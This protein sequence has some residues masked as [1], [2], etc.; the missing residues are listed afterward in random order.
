MLTGYGFDRVEWT[1]DTRS[2]A[3]S[4]AAELAVGKLKQAG[5]WV[6]LQDAHMTPDPDRAI[7]QLQEL[8]QK[9]YVD[10]PVYELEERMDR[11]WGCTCVCSGFMSYECAANKTAAKKAAAYQLLCRMMKRK[12]D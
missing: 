2:K 12:G 3:R 7:N 8:Y 10:R 11:Q 9:K 4:V 1:A 5:L 6:N